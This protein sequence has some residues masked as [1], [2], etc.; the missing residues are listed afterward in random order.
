MSC[1]E[2]VMVG[3]SFEKTAHGIKEAKRRLGISLNLLD[4]RKT[5]NSHPLSISSNESGWSWQEHWLPVL[6]S[7]WMRSWR[8]KPDGN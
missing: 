6:N 3:R 8:V 2:N 1:L 7:Y 5:A 4:L